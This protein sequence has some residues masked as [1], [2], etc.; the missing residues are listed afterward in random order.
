MKYFIQYPFLFLFLLYIAGCASVRHQPAHTLFSFELDNSTYEIIGLNTEEGESVNFLIHR[1]N[2]NTIFRVID[3]N[4]DGTLDRII[5]GS[6]DLMDANTIYQEG[7][8]Q[9][10]EQDRFREVEQFREYEITYNNYR[11]VIQ[12]VSEG[13][14]IYQNRFL[15]Y[16]TDWIL[17]G[18]FWD[19]DS[20]GELT[21]IDMGDIELN[22]AQLL[23]D[24]IL[25]RAS[26]DNR[27]DER[28]EERF[29]ITKDEPIKEIRGAVSYHLP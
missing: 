9:A 24:E 7:I 2:V 11:M 3:Y 15:I 4:Q 28:F 26:E 14:T 19:E 17:I 13:R 1:E 22:D 20:N 29:I 12:S 27:I 5:T 8:R 21:R 25:Q 10:M 23:Y 16:D 6:I 18:V